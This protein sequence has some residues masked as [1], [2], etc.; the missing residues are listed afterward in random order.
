[1]ETL[2]KAQCWSL[3]HSLWQG[4]IL[5]GAVFLLFLLFP[6][7]SAAKKHNVSFLALCLLCGWFLFTFF[8]KIDFSATR[9]SVAIQDSY[10]LFN[11]SSSPT[12]SQTAESWFPFLSTAYL[13]GLFIQLLITWQGSKILRK[14]RRTG[15]EDV[16]HSWQAIFISSYQKLG[17]KRIVAFQLS[18]KIEVPVVIG[19]IKPIVLF[20]VQLVN[21]LDTDQVEAILIHEL[22]HIKRN[23]FLINVI[24][25]AIQ[26]LLFFNPFM[27]MLNRYI[28]IEREN[29]CDDRVI[30]FT[31]QRIH[32]ANALLQLELV[33]R[34]SAPQYAMAAT[35][36]KQDLFT[37]IKRITLLKSNFMNTKQF[38]AT[39]TII[40][41]AL[42]SVAWILPHSEKK[43][44][45][46]VKLQPN[47]QQKSAVPMLL[48]NPK[49]AMNVDT[50]PPNSKQKVQIILT[51]SAGN[52]QSFHSMKDV[53]D[54]VKKVFGMPLDRNISIQIS[55]DSI[56]VLPGFKI[57]DI[58]LNFDSLRLMQSTIFEKMNSP[59]FKKKQEEITAYFNS[60]EF[61]EK[62]QE[63]MDK[64]N[65]P[66]FKKKQQE[67]MDKINS[68]EFKEQ[69]QKMIDRFKD[70]KLENFQITGDSLLIDGN[71]INIWGKGTL[72]QNEEYKNSEEYKKLREKYLKDLEKLKLKYKKEKESKK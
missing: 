20:P 53:P 41:A 37:R 63:I 69:Q 72:N 43:Q 14:L 16:P 64:I 12:F 9:A 56:H 34:K 68:P 36:K 40:I 45:E 23:D 24:Q 70:F 62:Q 7:M 33:K 66:E 48:I 44:S 2:I 46:V 59:E 30:D 22:T 10:F 32:Y 19:F 35:H 52:I 60:K 27:W 58:H 51:D 47:I 42:I 13:L 54:S 29:A 55:G 71:F 39:C 25:T 67:I 57:P 31:G 5:F 4:A 28:K 15:L 11:P 17:L 1:M 50:L 65:S 38:F 8:N 61:K 18:S 6:K 21:H 3:I 49:N 26:S